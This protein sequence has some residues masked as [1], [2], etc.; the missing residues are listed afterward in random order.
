[1]SATHTPPP[2]AV[3]DAAARATR[4]QIRGSSLLLA[5]RLLSVAAKMGAQVLVVR[6]LTTSEYGAWAYALAAVAFLGG[7]ATLSLDRA[8]GRFAAIYHQERQ[9]DRFFGVIALVLGTVCVTGV[10]FV[11]ALHV[12]PDAFGRLTGNDPVTLG[13]LLVMIFLVPLEALDTLLIALFATFGRPRAIFVRRYVITP[14]VQL[15]VVLLLILMSADVRFLAYGY[16][17]GA[18]LGVLVSLWLLFTILREQDL[19][20]HVR[21]GSIRVPFREL[22]SFSVPLMTSDWVTVLTSSSGALLLGYLYTSE[23]V[24]LLT[25]VMPVALLNLLVMQSFHLL[26]IPLASR[27]FAQGDLASIESLYWRTSLWIAVL[28]FP[29]F[30]VTF[31]AAL[32]LTVLLFGERYA[33]A[34]PVLAILA[35][36]QYVQAA[37]GFNG[38]TIKVLG[39]VRLLVGIN[40]AVAALNVALA[41]VL[42]PLFGVPGAAVTLTVTV[43]IHNLCKQ[44]GLRS[45]G[46]FR[47][48]DERYRAPVLTIVAGFAAL[49][50]LP[51]LGVRNAFVLTA[52][53]AAVSV[54]VVLR[55][56]RQLD[57]GDV[58]PEIE[59]HPLVKRLLT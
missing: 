30:A 23:H 19:L 36:G 59:R 56:R 34:A 29:L 9:Y 28:T 16:V 52:A 46:G 20:R 41:L 5:G 11:A 17:A 58:F 55:T 50:P 40:L 35:V 31:G 18:V 27:L 47:M 6:Y 4:S 25:V 7:F 49:L 2:P 15:S 57:V 54:W 43:I 21:P 51:L 3:S 44:A 8:V 38:S 1:V 33:A 42:V 10:L 53:A 45:A 24:G 32:P 12:F 22:L 13:L 14:A 26:F 48:L 39:R 37:L